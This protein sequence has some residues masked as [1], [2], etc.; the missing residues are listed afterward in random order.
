MS[1]SEFNTKIDEAVTA[2]ESGDLA[3]AVAKLDVAMVLMAKLPD[4]GADGTQMQWGRRD[5]LE[6]RKQWR[7]QLNASSTSGGI[8][9][10][11]L[12]PKRAGMT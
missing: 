8:R 2:Y 5:L 11:K 12:I 4:G 10:T 6:A 9:T 3:T 1:F 7:N